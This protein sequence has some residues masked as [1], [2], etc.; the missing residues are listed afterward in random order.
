MYILRNVLAIDGVLNMQY[1]ALKNEKKIAS[2]GNYAL[3]YADSGEISVAAEKKAFSLKSGFV[4][5]LPPESVFAVKAEKKSKVF[6]AL[7]STSSPLGKRVA[8]KV[9]PA[10]AFR[11]T[12]LSKIISASRNLFSE[13]PELNDVPRIKDDAGVSV[14]QIIKNCLET[15]ILDCVKPTIKQT[16]TEFENPLDRDEATKTVEKIYA[17]LGEKVEGRITLDEISETLYFS[18]SYL[19]TA[20]HKITG[21][22]IMRSFREMKIQEA[23]RLIRSGVSVADISDRLSFCNKNYFH[24]VFLSETGMTPA[25]YKNSVAENGITD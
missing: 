16:R 14:E 7:F 12:L 9:F 11:K 25:E 13:T 24:K 6:L 23:K 3:I 18:K 17:Y 15:F 1:F 4:S 20:F 5:F 21:K 22:T 10:G 2:S 19:K 8:W